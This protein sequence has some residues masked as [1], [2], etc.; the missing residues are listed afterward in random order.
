MLCVGLAA[1]AQDVNNCMK[2]DFKLAKQDYSVGDE[3]EVLF[4]V[5]L[6]EGWRL[7]LANQ[8]KDTQPAAVVFEFAENGSFEV[9]SQVKCQVSSE[10]PTE[11]SSDKHNQSVFRSTV[12]VVEDTFDLHGFVRGH[13]YHE[14]TGQMV[15]FQQS[16]RF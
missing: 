4:T 6:K 13:L 11:Q 14:P 2:W 16:F 12:R 3:L 10:K 15:A 1:E 7:I 5:S 8:P 9:L